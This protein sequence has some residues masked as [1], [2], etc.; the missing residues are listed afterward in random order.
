MY[1]T[2][3]H[4]AG[5]KMQEGVARISDEYLIAFPSS[6][7]RQLD[8][9]LDPEGLLWVSLTILIKILMSIILNG[10]HSKI[11]EQNLREKSLLE[12]LPFVSELWAI[13]QCS[14]VRTTSIKGNVRRKCELSYKRKMML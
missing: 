13:L 5:E 11:M 10:Q 4:A 7:T 9:G 1:G 3:L 12:E 6:T 14:I 8:S 2:E